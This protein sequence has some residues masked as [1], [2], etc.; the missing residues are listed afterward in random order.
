MANPNQ[1]RGGGS[2]TLWI[3][4]G[5]LM[6]ACGLFA[7]LGFLALALFGTSVSTT[8]VFVTTVVP[9]RPQ[10]TTQPTAPVRG[11]PLVPLPTASPTSWRAAPG[12]WWAGADARRG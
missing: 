9:L 1:R 10:F 3:V 5:A 6:A 2:M 8:T 4:L 11:T 12:P 7:V